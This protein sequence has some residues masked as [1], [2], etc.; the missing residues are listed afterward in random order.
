MQR[1]SYYSSYF[2]KKTARSS[3]AGARRWRKV[4]PA[5]RRR[6]KRCGF[7]C[8]MKWSSFVA[9]QQKRAVSPGQSWSKVEELH[10]RPIFE[11]AASSR[12]IGREG[13]ESRPWWCEV[14]MEGMRRGSV[15]KSWMTR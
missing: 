13:L 10:Q 5:G 3:A 2:D 4:G 11:E 9:D 1:M 8:A 14:E 6:R 15:Q 12:G 7:G